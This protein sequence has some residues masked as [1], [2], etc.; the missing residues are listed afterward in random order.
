MSTCSLLHNAHRSLVNFEVSFVDPCKGFPYWM[1]NGCK[2]FIPFRLL[3]VSQ[4]L[5]IGNYRY[6]YPVNFLLFHIFEFPVIEPSTCWTCAKHF[7]SSLGSSPKSEV[8]RFGI[9][10]FFS[11]HYSGPENKIVYKSHPVSDMAAWFQSPLSNHF[12]YLF[13]CLIIIKLLYNIVFPC[14]LPSLGLN[15]FLCLFTV[16]FLS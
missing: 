15:L 3:F 5:A 11:W 7:V 14:R 12:I 16:L 8:V 2:S 10:Y 6:Y 1:L 13:V 9:I 4:W